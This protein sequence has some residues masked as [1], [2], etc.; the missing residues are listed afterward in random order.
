MAL[1]IKNRSIPGDQSRDPA[2][3]EL[4]IYN[5]KAGARKSTEVGRA[6]IP[7][8]DGLGGKTTDASTQRSLPSGGRNLAI[9]NNSAAVHSITVGDSTVA[10]QAAGAVQTSG[11][12]YFVGVPCPPNQWT[13]LAA[14]Q[15]SYAIT[16]SATLL[17]FL[18]DDPTYIVTQPAN[19]AST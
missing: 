7:L 8:D 14:A 17:V 9:Y 12:N 1:Q 10:A 5:E 6:L 18:I 4:L 15:W 2:I 3:V 13:Y 16:D 19:N 11:S